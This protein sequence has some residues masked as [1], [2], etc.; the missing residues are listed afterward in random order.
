[1]NYE[2]GGCL[3]QYNS[4]LGQG[5]IMPN[6]TNKTKEFA[7]AHAVGSR[8]NGMSDSEF[9]YHLSYYLIKV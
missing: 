9:F 4:G 6:G 7:I 1:M 8:P 5:K 2:L 3:M